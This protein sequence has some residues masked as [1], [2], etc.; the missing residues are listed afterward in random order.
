[1]KFEGI[2]WPAIDPKEDPLPYMQLDEPPRIVDEPFTKYLSFW[3]DLQV[4]NPNRTREDYS[5]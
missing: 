2:P 1:M 4:R 5:N 3:D